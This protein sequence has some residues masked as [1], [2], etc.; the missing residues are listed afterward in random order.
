MSHFPHS[1]VIV[2][3]SL[4][5]LAT[6]IRLARAGLEVTILEKTIGFSQGTGIGIDRHQLSRLTGVSAFGT[7]NYPPLPV[8]ARPWESTNWS[9]LRDWLLRIAERSP[10]ITLRQGEDV[11][12]IQS[13]ETTPTV[14]TA[15]SHCAADIIVGADGY[16]STV[17]RFVD[18]S[19]PTATYAGY[20]LW[21]GTITETELRSAGV[22]LS[23]R[24]NGGSMYAGPYR[25]VI[26]EIPGA[27]TPGKPA[28]R[29]VNWVWY[30]PFLTAVFEAAGCVSDGVVRRSLLPNEMTSASLLHLEK[31]ARRVW[32][33]PW[34]SAIIATL[35]AHHVFATPV[36]EHLPRRL[37]RGNVA[38]AGDAAHVVVPATGAGLY[39]GLEDAQVLGQLV[40][41]ERQGG[42]SA[43]S[44]YEHSRLGMARALVQSSLEWSESFLARGN[45][46]NEVVVA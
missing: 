27:K 11:R 8:V 18:P 17:R 16:G 35:E 15:Q 25:L 30:D 42:A 23:G 32:P 44:C 24:W 19:H 41:T 40:E 45:L 3:G 36:A 10:M 26:Y 38:L 14:I 4:V 33:E 9:L 21:R 1:A 7:P 13:L 20:G 28:E 31:L 6:A 29:L 12:D 39:T 34:R 22:E 2:G 46:S 5:G 43:V 37:T